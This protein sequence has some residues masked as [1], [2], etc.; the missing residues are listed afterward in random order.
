LAGAEPFEPDKIGRYTVVQVYFEF[1]DE[2]VDF[3]MFVVLR[4]EASSAHVFCR[5]VK[6]TSQTEYYEERPELLPE[7]VIYEPGESLFPKRTIVAPR[8]SHN[9]AHAHFER[10]ASKKQFKILGKMPADFHQRLIL[11]ITNSQ[12][13]KPK[14]QRTLLNAI[15][16]GDH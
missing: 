3:K 16:A 10:Y 11:A 13:L 14:D 8:E 4:H 15:G 12:L 7:C 1:P 2:P 9:I 6:A 5:C